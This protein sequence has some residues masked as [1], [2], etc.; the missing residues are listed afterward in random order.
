MIDARAKDLMTSPA[1]ACREDA[2]FEEIADAL[3][4]R[5]ICGMPVVDDEGRVVGVILERDLAHAWGSPM[6]RLA[7]RRHPGGAIVR[8]LYDLPRRSRRARHLMTTPP[9]T[10]EEGTPLW[11]LAQ[12]MVQR[13]IGRIPVVNGAGTL[14]GVVTRGDVM[15]ALFDDLRAPG[16]DGAKT[17]VVGTD[18]VGGR[19]S[20]AIGDAPG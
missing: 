5:D 7:V 9:I 6:V 14:A 12:T 4:D 1:V 11:Q 16:R 18:H 3:A 10:C 15:R 13:D 20:I 8:D 17:I 2:F 19:P